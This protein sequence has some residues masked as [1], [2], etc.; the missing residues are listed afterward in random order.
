M[1]LCSLSLLLSLL[2]LPAQDL[3]TALRTFTEIYAV[4]EQEAAEPV[5]PEKAIFGGAIPG[6]LRPLDPHSVFL[7]PDQF[8][9]LTKLQ[10]SVSKGFGSVVSVLPGRVIVLQTLPGT[11]SARAGLAPGD[12]I[13]AINGIVLDR[14]DLEQLTALLEQSRRKPARLDVRRPGADRTLE[15]TLTPEEMQSPSVDRMFMLRPRVGYVRVASFDS[16]T[17]AELRRAIEKLGGRSLKALVLDLRNNPGG[18]VTAAVESASLFLKPGQTIVTVSGRAMAAVEQKVPEG[19]TPYE[20][21][22]AVLVNERTASAAEIVAGCLQDHRRAVIVGT[23]TF[24][25]GLVESVFPL[26]EGAGLA[27]TTAYYYTPKGRSIQKPLATGQL[28]KHANKDAAGGIRPDIIAGRRAPS[29][30]QMFLEASGAL[31]MFATEYLRSNP[32]PTED[33]QVTPEILDQLRG[34]LA[35]NRVLPGIAEWTQERTWIENHLKAEIFNQAFGVEK[36][37]EIEAQFDPAVLAALA[38]LEVK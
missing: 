30:L 26:S 23:P 32:H 16:E 8:E 17:G 22:V 11:P 10:Q 18:L 38:A 21:P 2:P 25:K 19:A 5:D 29:R 33:F 3:E 7:D 31:T 1:R 12:Q 35:A 36:G 13:I 20:F 28:S 37:E 15:F 24:G 4:L 27:L 34:F 14:L 6:M 9:Q